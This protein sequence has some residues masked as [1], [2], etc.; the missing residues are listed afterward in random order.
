MANAPPGASIESIE[1]PRS[2]GVV[3][4]P[5]SA[6]AICIGVR[7]GSKANVEAPDIVLNVILIS[8]APSAFAAGTVLAS[9]PSDLMTIALASKS[10]FAADSMKSLSETVLEVSI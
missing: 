5:F 8:L 7:E 4:S 1:L 6:F 9:F 2:K 3:L 10:S